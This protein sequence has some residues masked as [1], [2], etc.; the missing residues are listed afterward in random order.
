M[1]STLF[2]L[3]SFLPSS[4]LPPTLSFFLEFI[5]LLSTNFLYLSLCQW[6]GRWGDE[7]LSSK[8]YF[9]IHIEKLGLK[10]VSFKYYTYLALQ[11]G[12]GGQK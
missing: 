10:G 8:F 12:W 2:S 3:L 1:F 5:E 11:E 4:F 9:T 6:Q 7:K